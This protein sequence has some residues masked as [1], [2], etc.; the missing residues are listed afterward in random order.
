MRKFCITTLL[1]MLLVACG[2]DEERYEG[3]DFIDLSDS[4]DERVV[5]QEGMEAQ[6]ELLKPGFLPDPD[7]IQTG[8]KLTDYGM[9]YD[10]ET[11]ELFH[12][13]TYTHKLS[14]ASLTF[15]AEKKYNG[16]TV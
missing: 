5:I 12:E 15:K 7:A 6:R 9:T 13:V 11:G 3:Y 10:P 2:V 1:T 8:F 16:R 4:F 14:D